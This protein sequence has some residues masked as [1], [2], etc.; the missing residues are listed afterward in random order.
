MSYCVN[1]GVE[2]DPTQK[3]C[4]LCSVP[5]I[6]PAEKA[7]D[8]PKPYPAQ[9]DEHEAAFNKDLWVKLL[10]IILTTPAVI[11]LLTNLL[12][13]GT[14]T[15]ALYAVG[16]IVVAW[17]IG[18]SPFLFKKPAAIKWIIIDVVAILGYL[19][20]VEYGLS[21]YNPLF[22][23][24]WLPVGMPIVLGVALFTLVITILIQRKVLKELYIAA[25][26]FLAIAL[27]LIGVEIDLDAYSQ[28]A[29]ALEWSLFAGVSCAALSITFVILERSKKVKEQMRRRFHI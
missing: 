27:L 10:S 16:G 15:W 1:C 18:V 29:I 6:N 14:V 13:N 7:C 5:V 26:V 23:E 20:M 12:Y 25:A 28:S 21:L 2:L 17:A 19:K 11:C 22:R 8:E 3:K 9:R 4:P 24:W